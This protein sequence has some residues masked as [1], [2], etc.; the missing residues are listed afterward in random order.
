MCV[1]V[2]TLYSSMF[3]NTRT[4]TVRGGGFF[5]G[6]I[7]ELAGFSY[8]LC[9]WPKANKASYWSWW[10]RWA[11]RGPTFRGGGGGTL[12]IL[13]VSSSAFWFLTLT[14][15]QKPVNE[16][17]LQGDQLVQGGRWRVSRG[18]LCGKK[19]AKLI[20]LRSK[21]SL[22]HCSVLFP[23]TVAWGHPVWVL[24]KNGPTAIANFLIAAL[25]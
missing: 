25:F 6:A 19:A 5:G 14:I 1:L 3:G 7:P 15:I 9:A 22:A 11:S 24:S 13:V 23:P 18:D 2:L 21:R 10:A 16:F 20:E 17:R 4:H 8:S 12:Y